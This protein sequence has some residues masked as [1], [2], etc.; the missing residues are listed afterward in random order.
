MNKESLAKFKL[1]LHEEKTRLI[2]FGKCPSELRRKCGARR[3]E[4]F[5]FLGFTHYC[6]WSRGG[7]LVVK[8]RTDR[9]RLTRKLK[10]LGI[11]ARR[12]MHTPVVLQ[13]QWLCSA[14]RGHYAYFG[15]PSNWDRL[16]AFY[17]E[18]RRIWIGRSIAAASVGSRGSVMFGCWNVS[19]Y[20]FH[21]SRILDRWPLADLGQTSG[22]A[23]CGKA[24]RSDL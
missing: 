16:G 19:L 10:E 7:R 6:A 21:E 9:M 17:Q 20:L 1:A 2:E 12:R 3:G 22:G 15:L 18:T 23:E 24:A 8:R 11:Q 13:Y 14:L 5:R 4:T